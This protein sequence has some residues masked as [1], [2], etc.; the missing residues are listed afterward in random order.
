MRYSPS[1]GAGIVHSYIQP[2]CKGC[3]RHCDH[4]LDFARIYKQGLFQAYHVEDDVFTVFPR[5]LVFLQILSI[6]TLLLDELIQVD[7]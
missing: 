7:R 4:L 1:L 3:H 5:P 2:I 6:L